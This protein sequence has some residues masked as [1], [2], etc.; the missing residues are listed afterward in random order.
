MQQ[1]LTGPAEGMSM[2]STRA[3]SNAAHGLMLD[4]FALPL[5]ADSEFFNEGM[6]Q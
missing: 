1:I 3:V 2:R 5:I 4:E 6:L